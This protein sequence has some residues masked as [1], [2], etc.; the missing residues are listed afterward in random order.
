MRLLV[1]QAEWLRIISYYPARPQN[2]RVAA[3]RR[4]GPTLPG[5]RTVLLVLE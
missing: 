4:S 1:E 5:R 2:Q 3:T